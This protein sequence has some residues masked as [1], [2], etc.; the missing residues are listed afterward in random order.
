M[1]PTFTPPLSIIIVGCGVFGLSTARTL[2]DRYP[3]T[4]VTVIDKHAFPCPYSASID[5]SRIV[6]ADYA[7]P[8]YSILG[9]E[10][11]R[12]WAGHL[13]FHKTGLV[14]T[15]DGENKYLNDSYGNVKS[16]VGVE[17]L[18]TEKDIAGL[19]AGGCSGKSGYVNWNSGWVD[20]ETA[21]RMLHSEVESRENV[22]FLIAEV[23][24]LLYS[25]RRVLG[26]KLLDGKEVTAGLTILAAGA[27]TPGLVPLHGRAVP[28]GQ[29]IAYLTLSREEA[30]RYASLPVLL[31]L[32]T[33]TLIIHSP[34]TSPPTLKFA[35]HAQGYASPTPVF[36]KAIPQEGEGALRDAVKQLVPEFSER[37][38]EKT[39]VCWYTDTPDG[40]FLVTWHPEYEGLFIASGGSGHAFKFLPVLGG[41]IVDVLVGKGRF[42]KK[43]GWKEHV[44]G[45]GD[46][47]RGGG[48]AGRVPLEELLLE[49]GRSKL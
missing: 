33:G 25:G 38:F 21:M 43:W 26:V 6:R 34:S 46:G 23:S 18:P 4:I 2:S 42:G 44:G 27:W 45:L 49:G 12:H 40:D 7:D 14:V 8:A 29:V 11:L 19:M 30:I 36:P 1:A 37:P 15:A 39:R 22:R 9:R 28:S 3:S 10:A 13:A 48:D 17:Y 24:G 35:R 16:E 47:S 41:E 20:A 5:S 31:N 32:T